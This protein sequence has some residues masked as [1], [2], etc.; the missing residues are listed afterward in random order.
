MPASLL[1]ARAHTSPSHSTP[2]NTGGPA[3]LPPKIRVQPGVLKL[4]SKEEPWERLS[5]LLT[6]RVRPGVYRGN[7]GTVTSL[8]LPSQP[9]HHPHHP[10]Q[11][12]GDRAPA[13]PGSAPSTRLFPRGHRSDASWGGPCVPSLCP[14]LAWNAVQLCQSPI[15]GHSHGVATRQGSQHARELSRWGAAFP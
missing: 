14:L 13:L 7:T 1:Q 8:R 5:P 2:T 4:H 12:C 10:H 6:P 9:Q 11:V 15:P 3:L